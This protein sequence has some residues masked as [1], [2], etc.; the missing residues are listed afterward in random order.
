MEKQ[1][2]IKQLRKS[3]ARCLAEAEGWLDD[4]RG[5]KPADIIGYDGW[6]D[7]A[8]RLLGLTNDQ[9][10]MT[11][12]NRRKRVNRRNETDEELDDMI[13]PWTVWVICVAA[14]LVFILVGGQ[15]E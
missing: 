14:V 1:D 11:M 8:R 10:N 13:A 6:A 4:A 3:L 2:E 7:E 12:Y 9:G 15:N 5:C